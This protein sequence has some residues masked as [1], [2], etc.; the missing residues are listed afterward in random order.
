MLNNTAPLQHFNTLNQ[1]FGG[2]MN[3]N[4]YTR[5]SITKRK[6]KI[7]DNKIAVIKNNCDKRGL[8]SNVRRL[9]KLFKSNKINFRKTMKTLQTNRTEVNLPIE[10]IKEDFELLFNSK[11][12][13]NSP[14]ELE[15][16]KEIAENM[17]IN[18]N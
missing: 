6:I 13:T 7:I 14:Q 2:V 4:N 11:L 16:I 8:K 5:D 1:K 18:S 12:V 3:A 15:A 17:T 9:N 10:K